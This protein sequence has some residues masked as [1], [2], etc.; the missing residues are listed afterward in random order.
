VRS[1]VDP[2]RVVAVGRGEASGRGG[3]VRIVE[4]PAQA[5]QAQAAKAGGAD[6]SA[7][8]AQQ[9]VDP[10]GTSHFESSNVTTVPRGTSAM[11][12]ILHASTDGEV[13]YLYDAESARGNAAFPF[14]AMRLWNPTD[15]T[16]ESGPVSVFGDGRF[17]GEGLCEP[18]PAKST[19]FVPFALD[20]QIVVEHEDAEHDEI[21]R[22]LAVQRGVFAT[23]VK[24]TKRTTITLHNRSAERATV[25]VRHTVAPGY[26]LTKTPGPTERVGAAHLVRVVVEPNAKTDLSLE[27]ETPLFK[28]TDIRAPQGLE[29][30]KLF[31]SSAAEGQLKAQVA[32]L[33]KLSKEMGT[34][35]QQIA[36]M[37]D[38]M[39]EYRQRMDELH[40]QIVTL[41]AV[42]SAGP[43]MQS[44]ERKL[45]EM[46]DKV[47]KGT[48]DLVGLEEKRM[49]A[50]I[51]FEDGV[52]DLTLEKRAL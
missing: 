30:V 39:T 7:P 24:H 11:V 47:S 49:V 4:A 17:V 35:D 36:T 32:E 51:H 20:R 42:K 25:Y 28:T 45:Q 34:I 41:R 31:L 43:L 13:V 16:L 9:Q 50:R 23:E 37:H 18:I 44:L 27:E 3:G 22:I 15:S 14:R 12:S 19:A 48:I 21:A 2:S 5:A 26:T 46:S 52:A 29:L 10:I 40:A 38:Q 8:A 6:A 1:G 33:V